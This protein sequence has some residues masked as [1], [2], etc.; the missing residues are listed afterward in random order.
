MKK[1]EKKRGKKINYT[2]KV[3]NIVASANLGVTLDLFN[4]AEKVDNIEYEPEQFPGAIMKL[5]EF[6]TSLLLF[7]NGKVIV[8]GAKS[9]KIIRS[10]LRK[11][12]DQLSVFV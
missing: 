10:S 1:A 7:K 4:L 8:A 5:K 9:E 12:A 3:V 11:A 2:Y 6:G